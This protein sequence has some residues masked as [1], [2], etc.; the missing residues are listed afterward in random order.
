MPIPTPGAANVIPNNPPTLNVISNKFVHLGQT[1]QFT[2]TATD[3]DS[4]Y[5]T[6]AFSLTNSPA[7][8]TIDPANG[9]FSL[10]GDKYYRARHQFRHRRS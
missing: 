2:A 10:G 1:V 5:Q 6:L 7:G 9:A 3:P 8:A 4:W